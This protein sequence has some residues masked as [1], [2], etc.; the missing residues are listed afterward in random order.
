MDFTREQLDAITSGNDNSW[1]RIGDPSVFGG[2]YESADYPG[3]VVKIQKGE[4]SIYDNEINK[5]FE[6]QLGALDADYE[7]PKLGTT[8]FI[9]YDQKPFRTDKGKLASDTMGISFIEMDRANFA[10]TQGAPR[11]VNLAKAKGLIDLFRQ[12]GVVHRDRHSGNIKFNP[13]TNKAVILDYA[14][15]VSGDEVAYNAMRNTNVRNGLRA[16]GNI[17][18]LGLFDESYQNALGTGKLENV[19][20]ILDQGEEVVSMTDRRIDPVTFT[21]NKSPG[22]ADLQSYTVTS[23]GPRRWD[24]NDGLMTPPEVRDVKTGSS[25]S[26]LE[27][28]SKTRMAAK[29]WKSPGFQGALPGIADLIPSAESVR[30]FERGG[31]KEGANQMMRESALAI[32]VGA[33]GALVTSSLPAI[34]PFMPGIAGGMALTE[35]ARTVNEL[36]RVQTGEP[37]IDKAR[38]FMGTQERTGLSAPGSSVKEKNERRMARVDNPPQ[39]HQINKDDLPTPVKDLPLPEVGR[40]V[41]MAKERFN[42]GKGEFGITELLFGR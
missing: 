8:N 26:W 19:L 28:K 11:Q 14:S 41:R 32:P 15:A 36:T 10:E 3:K 6:A 40:R 18:M 23:T 12:S 17:D 25:P 16:S 24:G 29:V 31:V 42:P 13:E 9:P 39:I 34:A 22:R 30:A 21:N 1:R 7:V 33:G 35:G 20:D 5:Q 27:P 38:Q 37:L 4:F 2:V